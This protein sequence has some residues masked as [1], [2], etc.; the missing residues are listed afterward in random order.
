MLDKMRHSP[1]DG[2]GAVN[3]PTRT[4]AGSS[5]GRNAE[6]TGNVKGNPASDSMEWTDATVTATPSFT[7]TET[8]FIATLATVP[9]RADFGPNSNYAVAP[10]GN[11]S[12]NHS[13]IAPRIST[14]V[15][16]DASATAPMTS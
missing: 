6:N 14:A 4:I 2:D 9:T 11:S 5:S 3:R 16:P 10:L 8:G 13:W 15:S 12:I 1:A 7:T